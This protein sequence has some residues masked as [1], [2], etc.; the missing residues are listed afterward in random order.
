MFMRRE[1]EVSSKIEET[2][3]SVRTLSLAEQM[4][5]LLKKPDVREVTNNVNVLEMGVESIKTLPI[6]LS[7]IRQLHALLFEGIN[8]EGKSWRPGEFRGVQ[9]WIGNSNNPVEARFVPPPPDRV[10]WLMRDLVD[11]INAQDGIN[12]ILK[13]GLI[14]YQFETIHPFGDGNGRIGRAI[15]LLY[16]IQTGTFVDPLLNP[17]SQLE[18]NRREY[19]D[20]LLAIS[21]GVEGAWEAWLTFFCRCLAIE[22]ERSVDIITKL[23]L[24]RMAYHDQVKSSGS[25]STRG[26]MT[27]LVDY[28]IGR[29]L[30]NTAVVE[31]QLK[32]NTQTAIRLIDKLVDLK[33]LEEVTGKKRGR[34]YLANEVVRLFQNQA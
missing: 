18:R 20:H 22:A 11:F 14:H 30:V 9:N 7:L 3:A 31:S 26:Y 21:Q 28:L 16:L 27:A 1:A 29:P 19:Y 23:E 10:E 2:H 6:S 13:A 33:I 15:V 8:T 34:I 17:S 24:L 25:S 4:P 5:D 32:C 12:P